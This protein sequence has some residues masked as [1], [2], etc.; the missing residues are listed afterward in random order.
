MAKR[1]RRNFYDHL[2]WAESE[3]KAALSVAS[4]E[5]DFDSSVR[6]LERAAVAV[7]AARKKV[8]QAER[9]KST[10]FPAEAG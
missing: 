5:K 9:L 4:Q 10:E 7:K 3:I 8:I 2:D 6:D 1:D